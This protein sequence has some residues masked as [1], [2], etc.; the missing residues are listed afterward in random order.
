MLK[1][2]VSLLLALLITISTAACS[3]GEKKETK[4]DD[5]SMTNVTSFEE[6]EI[7]AS[8][9]LKCP[10]MKMTLDSK[11]QLVLNDSSEKGFFNIVA[12][13]SGKKL[14]EYKNNMSNGL[15][16]LFILDVNMHFK[17]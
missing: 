15:G 4:A 8:I 9:G 2:I 6:K 12:D 16:T 5:F 1:R 3:G 11:N 10:G 17:R 14:Q 13:G 7:G